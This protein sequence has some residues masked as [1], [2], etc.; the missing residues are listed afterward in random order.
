[1]IDTRIK[2]RHLQSFLEAGRLG[3]IAQ[4]AEAL[5]VSQPAVSKTL[6]EL[7]EILGARLFHRSKKGVRL[8]RFG[9][10]FL[11]HASA[12][13]LALRQ[14]IDSV[15]RARSRGDVVVSAG[16]LPNVASR[17][18]PRALQLFKQS[19]L[20]TVVRVSTG[21]NAQ[22]LGQLRQGELDLVVG[23]LVDPD[24]MTGLSFEHIYS[25]PMTL[26]VRPGHPLLA[27]R[28]F[29]LAALEAYPASLPQ[30]GTVIR[31][32]VDRFLIANG[33]GLS[34]DQVETI[35]V[36][37]GRAY[38][39]ATDAV[40]AVPRGAVIA[41]IEAGGLVELPIDRNAM[42]GAIG[43]TTRSDVA[44]TPLTQLLMNTIREVAGS[45]RA[46]SPAPT[47]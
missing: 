14:G 42:L 31:R 20:E 35:S 43:L 27:L 15:T 8:T 2:F 1:M 46:A 7:E 39:L 23:R 6:K 11:R 18:M 16:V 10:I 5:G 41:D 45:I 38:A 28:P 29:D 9:E 34:A 36:T 33:V 13:V 44:P 17:V 32:E 25:E 37:F 24:Q 40:W 12:S 4:A 3:S 19:A 22:L 30:R 26:V 21:S 47:D